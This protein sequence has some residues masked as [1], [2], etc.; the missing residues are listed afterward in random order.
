MGSLLPTGSEGQGESYVR[1]LTILLAA[2]GALM[3]IP[4]AQAFA[5][6]PLTVNISGTGAGKVIVP[7]EICCYRGSPEIKCEYK[8]PGP[9]TGTCKPK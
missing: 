9:A 7:P 1:R 4:A 8:S 3:L 2:V 5:N 6:E